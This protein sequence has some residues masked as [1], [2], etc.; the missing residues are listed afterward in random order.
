MPT[1]QQ[2]AGLVAGSANIGRARDALVRAGFRAHIAG[3]RI[4]VDDEVFAQFA[5]MSIDPVTG[6]Y[7][8]WL[9]YPANARPGTYTVSGPV[10][11]VRPAN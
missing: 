4:I 8:R 3:N 5:G 7:P 2:V 11:V 6:V 1:A 10:D 9:V